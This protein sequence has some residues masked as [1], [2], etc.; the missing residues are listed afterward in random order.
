MAMETVLGLG[1]ATGR[2]LVLPPEQ[3][4][5]LLGKDRSKQ[6]SNFGFDDFFPMEELARGERW[7]KI[8]SM[9]EFSKR[10]QR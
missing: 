6:K 3:R 1:I 7:P 10:K 9:K 2:T 8:I 4:M 5:Y